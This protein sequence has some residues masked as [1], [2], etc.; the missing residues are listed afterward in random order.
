MMAMTTSNSISVNAP[1]VFMRVVLTILGR[2]CHVGRNAR[3][4]N[5]VIG[6]KTE[7]ADYSRL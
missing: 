7:I 3:L 5:D 2:S 1:L 4:E 6:D